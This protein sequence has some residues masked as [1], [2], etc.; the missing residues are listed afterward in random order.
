MYVYSD[1]VMN[2]RAFGEIGQGMSGVSWDAGYKRP[3]ADKY[4]RL[5]V[6]INTGRTTL[7]KGRQVPIREHRLVRDIVNNQGMMDPTWQMVTNATALRKEEW[8]QLDTKVLR[9]ARYRLRAWGDLAQA[10]SYGGFNGMA[11]SILE[12]ETMTDPGEA[13]VDMN[14]IS[15]G[16]GDQPQ[17]Q[18]QG[19][20]LPI[21][22]SDFWFDSRTLAISRNS[23]TP[24][25]VNMGE[26]CGRRVAESVEKTL[27]G[28]K[29]GIVYGGNSTQIGGYGRASQVY[30]YTNFP[31][32]LTK[33]NLTAPNGTNAASTLAD[34]LAMRD[35]LTIQKFYG[36][37]IIY[38]TNDWD[39]YLD[40]DYILTGGNVAT[41]TLRERLE[42]IDEVSACKRLDFFFGTQPSASTGPGTSVDVVLKPTR[43][44]MVQ[45][46]EDVAQAVNGLDMTT[47]QWPD[48]GGLKLNFKLMTIQ[49]GRLRCDA[50]GNVGILD[51]T[52]S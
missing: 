41:Q 33:T 16:R 34:V 26:A 7:I 3:Y 6:T 2:G 31:A 21:T 39:R 1:Y 51:A 19:L 15:E 40:G 49:V 47:L 35:Q 28:M 36:P 44:L 32:R 23:G 9:A 17:F 52:T 43:F 4:G 50:Y 42:A 14:G 5:S 37:W 11:K 48:K 29:T 30:G 12:W 10:N 46:T 22:H 18:L 8:D 24:L 25:D 13:I 38:H 20:P 45:M 27:I